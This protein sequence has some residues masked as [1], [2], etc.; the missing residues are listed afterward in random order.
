MVS[1][2]RCKLRFLKYSNLFWL[3]QSNCLAF[4][5]AEMSSLPAPL[6]LCLLLKLNIYVSWNR[7]G[8]RWALTFLGVGTRWGWH[9]LESL[10][11]SSVLTSTQ[12]SLL[13]WGTK[14]VTG[15]FWV[16]RHI[17][18]LPE[19]FNK[20]GSGTKLHFSYLS[21]GLKT[22]NLQLLPLYFQVRKSIH[23]RPSACMTVLYVQQ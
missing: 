21:F 15:P 11:G 19:S 12:I 9:F 23:T 5:Q 17:I 20:P 16:G 14:C 13:L 18:K 3:S 1:R 6:S 22:L 10:I 8:M 4:R 2:L 7:L